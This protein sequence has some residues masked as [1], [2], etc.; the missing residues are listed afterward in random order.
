MTRG[1]RGSGDVYPEAKLLIASV[2]VMVFGLAMFSANRPERIGGVADELVEASAVLPENEG[3]LVIV[4]GTPQLVDGGVIVD[5]EAGLR[6]ENAVDYLR[7]PLQKVYRLKS[8]E[9]VVDKGEDKVSEVDDVKRTEYYVAK[10]WVIASQQ[11]DAVIDRTTVRYENP[12]PVNMDVFTA[13]GD[14][15]V[16]GFAVSYADV[17][18]YITTNEC[19]FTQQ[20]LAAACGPFITRSELDL[21]VVDENGVGI[22][23]SGDEV[24]DVQVRFSYDT[25]ESA[26]PVTLVGRQRGDRIV[27]EEEEHLS[28]AEHVQP[29]IVSR[30]EFLDAISAE[31]ASSRGYGVG[32]C[33]LGA[34]LFLASLNLGRG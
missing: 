3:K 7:L 31:D 25:L 27:L 30:E 5:E 19:R 8:R 17:S 9:V 33:A 10:E 14:L 2:I 26:E 29:G 22:L 16:A 4:S 34:I 11:R 23:S 12:S 24:G 21:K 13:S 32:F 28:D 1:Q 6:V 20:E 18:R 15:R